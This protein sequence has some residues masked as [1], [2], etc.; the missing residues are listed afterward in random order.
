[1]ADSPLP[2]P[3]YVSNLLGD[4]NP[5][6]SQKTKFKKVFYLCSSSLLSL[7]SHNLVEQNIK[8][9]G[10]YSHFSLSI[11]YIYMYLILWLGWTRGMA[12]LRLCWRALSWGD[13]TD[14]WRGSL[15]LLVFYACGLIRQI[16]GLGKLYMCHS[17]DSIRIQ[18]NQRRGEKK[19]NSKRKQEHDY[20]STRMNGDV[21]LKATAS[22]TAEGEYSF[23]RWRRKRLCTQESI[24]W[25][26]NGRFLAKHPNYFGGE[27]KF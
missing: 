11:F 15:S 27:Q 13:L 7:N 2:R 17:F 3:R 26:K 10:K 21:T 4:K 5:K 23:R 6:E 24:F 8:V 20:L 12:L 1:M 18:S 25:G 14:V 19:D 16:I 22:A 9:G